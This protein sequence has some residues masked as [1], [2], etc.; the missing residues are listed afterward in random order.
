MV[1]DERQHHVAWRTANG[2]SAPAF[3]SADEGSVGLSGW[4]CYSLST[5]IA[6]QMKYRRES[7]REKR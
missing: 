2:C 3:L 6:S 1:V 7:R 5:P 4:R